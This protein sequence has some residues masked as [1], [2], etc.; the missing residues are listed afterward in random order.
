MA[1]QMDEKNKRVEK[2][3]S[4]KM[5]RKWDKKMGQENGTRQWDKKIVNK[6]TK[7]ATK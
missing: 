6:K 2:W 3:E 1:R 5:T 4:Y 7:N